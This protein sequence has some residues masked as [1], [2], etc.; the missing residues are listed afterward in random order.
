MATSTLSTSDG[1]LRVE[2]EMTPVHYESDMDRNWRFTDSHGHEHRCEY[3]AA[4]HYPTLR[5]VVDEWCYRDHGLFG[6]S[7]PDGHPAAGHYECRQ[8]GE[9]VS[10]GVTGPGTTMIAGLVT[11][12][13]DDQPVSR[14]RAEEFITAAA[15]AQRD[16]EARTAARRVRD[17]FG[18]RAERDPW[19]A[20]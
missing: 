10:P 15:A 17:G 13:L 4:D 16:R 12:Y 14:E 1:I 8:C 2:R 5:Y 18:I 19:D 20:L 6:G 7:D 9:T 11:Y 3:E